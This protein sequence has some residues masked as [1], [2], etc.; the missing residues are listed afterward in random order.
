[1]VSSQSVS[2]FHLISVYFSYNV[3]YLLVD[4]ASFKLTVK[5]VF[6]CFHINDRLYSEADSVP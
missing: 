5:S 4:V 2:S 3:S 6:T 1:M